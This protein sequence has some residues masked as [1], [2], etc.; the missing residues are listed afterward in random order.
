MLNLPRCCHIPQTEAIRECIF[1]H[2][3]WKKHQLIL[4]SWRRCQANSI[5]INSSPYL[6]FALSLFSQNSHSHSLQFYLFVHGE[7]FISFSY[8]ATPLD[9]SPPSFSIFLLS[10]TF[11]HLFFLLGFTICE[12]VCTKALKNYKVR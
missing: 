8:I 10:F 7:L 6:Y 9:Y 11:I 2:S 4:I 12:N 1:V 3:C 5:M